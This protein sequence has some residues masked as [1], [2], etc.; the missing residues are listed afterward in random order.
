MEQW[1]K[2]QGVAFLREIGIK[3]GQTVLDFGCRVGHYTIPA[4]KIVGNNGIVHA[5]DTEEYSLKELH[6]KANAHKLTNIN[7]IKTS[8]R[9][10]LP[11]E[12][13]TIDIVLFYDVLHYLEKSNRKELYSE[14]FRILKQD[15]FL[16]VYPKHTLED[17]PLREFSSLS[18][19]DVKREIEDSNF[20]FKHKHCSLMSHDDG[21]NQGCVLNFSKRR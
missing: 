6:K 9:T 18:A 2:Q 14:A 17:N 4:A 12:R 7:T 19:S 3:P 20:A 15:G 10:R 13:E 5:I 8:G 16:S 21:L 1:E 11:L